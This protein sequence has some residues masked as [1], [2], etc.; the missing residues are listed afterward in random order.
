VND[1]VVFSG[2]VPEG[3]MRVSARQAFALFANQLKAFYDHPRPCSLGFP[4]QSIYNLFVPILKVL[5]RKAGSVT[6]YDC[7]IIGG[8]IVG[9]TTAWELSRRGQ[10]VLILD[11]REIGREASWAAAGMLP[12]V[13]IAAPTSEFQSLFRYSFDCW[14]QT[15]PEVAVDASINTGYRQCGSS[16]LYPD[17]IH[18]HAGEKF[19]QSHGF[20]THP[21]SEP[22]PTQHLGFYIHQHCQVMPRVHLDA[23]ATACRQRG[24]EILEHEELVGFLEAGQGSQRHFEGI[25]TQSGHYRGHQILITSG[26]W[27]GQVS[28]LAGIQAPTRPIRGQILLLK[29]HQP[30]DFG[31]IEMHFRY[32]VSRLDGTVLVGS[33]MDDVGFEHGVT[34]QGISTLK[35][36]A[37]ETLPSLKEADV[38]ATWSGLRPSTADGL[39]LLGR[40]ANCDNLWI[41]CGHFRNGILLSAGTAKLMTQAMLGESTDL[42]L[43]PFSPS[44]LS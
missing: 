8:G 39:P 7:I 4:R 14:K 38:L 42:D 25:A 23:L 29:P 32:L 12:P 9:L 21:L 10:R 11:R 35:S 31:I 40:A 19:W 33:T 2:M 28:H 43:K 30:Q 37:A 1:A 27:T 36:F 24:V 18:F 20:Q 13:D 41:A 5:D 16:L 6:T 22:A 44:R 3:R 15:G 26:S 34:E 17:E